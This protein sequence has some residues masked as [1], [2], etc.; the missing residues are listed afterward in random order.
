MGRRSRPRSW[1]R[2]AAFSSG[3]GEGAHSNRRAD[4]ANR[5]PPARSSRTSSRG[6]AKPHDRKAAWHRLGLRRYRA[7]ILVEELGLRTQRIE[8]MIG[9]LEDFS[10]RLE[11]L[12]AQVRALRDG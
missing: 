6:Q 9:T 12:R 7:V 11:G 4:D 5:R 3:V 8:T 10:Y 1:Q 2:S